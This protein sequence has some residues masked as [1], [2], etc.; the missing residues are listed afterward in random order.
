MRFR[1]PK[2]DAR[3]VTPVETKHRTV[4]NA[5]SSSAMKRPM[6]TNYAINAQNI[7]AE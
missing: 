4:E 1:G 3:G 6:N 7:R 5:G 2:T